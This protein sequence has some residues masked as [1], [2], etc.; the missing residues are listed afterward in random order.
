M[1]IDSKLYLHPQIDKPF[2]YSNK[3]LLVISIVLS[4]IVLIISIFRYPKI[5]L[6]I[7]VS[8][9]IIFAIYSLF[10]KDMIIKN[11]YIKAKYKPSYENKELIF[12]LIFKLCIIGA[13]F[14]ICTAI[15]FSIIF[16]LILPYEN[17]I[18]IPG[19]IYNM[20]NNGI[21]ADNSFDYIVFMS[22]VIISIVAFII[23]FKQK[24]A[25]IDALDYSNSLGEYLNKNNL[26]EVSKLS[27]IKEEQGKIVN[28]IRG[29]KNSIEE[30]TLKGYKDLNIYKLL[31]DEKTKQQYSFEFGSMNVNNEVAK[32]NIRNHFNSINTKINIDKEKLKDAK[33]I[34]IDNEKNEKFKFMRMVKINEDVESIIRNNKNINQSDIFT[35]PVYNPNLSNG[36]IYSKNKLDRDPYRDL[37]KHYD[38][39][40]CYLNK[41]I[42]ELKSKDKS[43]RRFI[44]NHI[45]KETNYTKNDNK[46][47]YTELDNKVKFNTQPK[48]IQIN[49]KNK[50]N[51]TDKKLELYNQIMEESI[52]RLRNIDNNKKQ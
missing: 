20:F 17:I 52:E 42:N 28:K 12:I 11:N 51:D 5:L 34:D 38:D 2:K 30:S 40:I 39:Y 19:V 24:S 48:T 29:V 3:S 33:F 21:G 27:I 8:F 26:D 9:L 47:Y 46:L 1:K 37:A 14:R 50:Y 4:I 32:N 45:N 31:N 49:I 15:T 41:N 6:Q 18:N 23:V 36:I 22:V 25:T 7:D 16:S 10:I 13:I 35:K 43:H 44:R